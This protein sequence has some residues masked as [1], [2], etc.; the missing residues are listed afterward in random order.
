M[1]PHNATFFVVIDHA[2]FIPHNV[3]FVVTDHA[4]FIPHNVEQEG[5][6]SDLRI[7]GWLRGY[8]DMWVEIQ[9]EG[10][11]GREWER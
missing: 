11:R 10:G 5:N 8:E 7:F 2:E 4:D 1:I 9:G 6:G 3:F